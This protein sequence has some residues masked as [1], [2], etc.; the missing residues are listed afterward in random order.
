MAARTGNF[1]TD[2]IPRVDGQP[3]GIETRGQKPQGRIH[4]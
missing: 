2:L 1:R 3:A 4:T